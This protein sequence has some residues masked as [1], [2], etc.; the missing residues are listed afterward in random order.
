M[1]P[2]GLEVSHQILYLTTQV[3]RLLVRAQGEYSEY[4]NKY[5]SGRGFARRTE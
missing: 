4:H 2:C 3:T 5:Q 1:Q